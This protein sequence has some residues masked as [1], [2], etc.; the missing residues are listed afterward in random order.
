VSSQGFKKLPPTQANGGLEWAT[1]PRERPDYLSA[2]Q[3][4][5]DGKPK[6]VLQQA[7]IQ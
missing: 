6:L 2:S 1:R 7:L 5:T 3:A 4:V